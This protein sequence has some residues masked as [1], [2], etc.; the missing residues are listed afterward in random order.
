MVPFSTIFV[1]KVFWKLLSKY[2]R[3]SLFLVNSHVLCYLSNKE[4]KA[5]LLVA[6]QSEVHFQ[7]PFFMCLIGR[8]S[9]IAST[10]IRATRKNLT[11]PVFLLIQNFVVLTVQRIVTY[12]PQSLQASTGSEI[13]YVQSHRRKTMRQNVLAKQK[14]QFKI[15]F[16]N[17]F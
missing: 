8:A 16:D 6:S 12:I 10:K 1:Q 3:Q 2:L 9:K 17:L 7:D 4:Q 5:M 14:D 11:T 13:M 15:N